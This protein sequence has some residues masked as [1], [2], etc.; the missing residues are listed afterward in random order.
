[1][2]QLADFANDRIMVI[3]Q[4]ETAKGLQVIEEIGAVEGVDM[5]FF[6]PGDMSLSLGV[7]PSSPALRDAMSRIAQVA[8]ASGKHFG[9]FVATEEDARFAASQGA[10]L[11]VA[12]ADVALLSQGARAS[13][14]RIR[15][16]LS[17]G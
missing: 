12:G 4:I 17:G 9:T 1:M 15:S 13:S 8:Q 2:G 5:L 7:P 10:V 14:E 16:A 3:A 6:G 11:V